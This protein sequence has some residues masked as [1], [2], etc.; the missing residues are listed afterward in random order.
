M[1]GI[2]LA[3]HV[4]VT[5]LLIFIILVQKSEGGSSL[6]ASGAGNGMFTARGTSDI[7]T[8]SSWVLASI[9]LGNCIWMAHI[10][11]K[12]IKK[13]NS[14]IANQHLAKNTKQ[15]VGHSEPLVNKQNKQ[16][17]SSTK[18]NTRPTKT[19]KSTKRTTRKTVKSTTDQPQVSNSHISNA[20]K[21]EKNE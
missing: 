7:L 9:F 8:K 2:L 4:I 20:V 3:I 19:N 21:A 11:S 10:S 17:E 5:I 13:T 1:F 14:I 16:P 6:F 15:V 12:D 18:K